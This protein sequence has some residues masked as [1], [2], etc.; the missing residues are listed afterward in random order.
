MSRLSFAVAVLAAGLVAGTADA[1]ILTQVQGTVLVN[2]GSGFVPAG[3]GFA[4]EPGNQVMIQGPGQAVVDFG[5]GQTVTV[6][7]S[8][9]I[10]V[11][12]PGVLPASG[13]SAK[14]IIGSVFTA[15]GVGGIIAIADTGGSNPAPLPISP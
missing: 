3:N 10:V 7:G 6:P 12:A 4:V 13:L 5:N 14:V 11:R 2:A 1:A 15:A 9:T 8:S